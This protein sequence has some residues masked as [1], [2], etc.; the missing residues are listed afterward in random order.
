MHRAKTCSDVP[1]IFENKFTCPFDRYPTNFSK[2]NFALPK[3][4]SHKSKCKISI[5]G[6]SLWN[7]VLSNTEKELQGTSL[8][9]GKLKSKLLKINK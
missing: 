5:R 6:F 2:S 1:S 8:F 9:K 3:Y 4:L 7:K